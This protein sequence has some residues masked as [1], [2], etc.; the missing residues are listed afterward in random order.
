MK[1]IIC[2]LLMLNMFLLVSAGV[3]SVDVDDDKITINVYGEGSIADTN[4]S[5]E[6]SGAEVLLGNTTCHSITPFLAAAGSDT[7]ETTRVNALVNTDCTGTDKVIGVY[8]NGTVLCGSDQTG[9]GGNIKAGDGTYTYNDTTIIYF[10]STYAGINLAV[11]DSDNWDSMD[12]IN[13]TQMENNGGVLNF[14]Q[15]WVSS[16]FDNFLSEKSTDDLS[17]GTNKY[18]NE[19]WN[20][21]QASSIYVPYLGATGTVNLSTQS[22]FATAV[23]TNYLANVLGTLSLNLTE[24]NVFKP[25]DDNVVDLGE[26][27]FK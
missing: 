1:R 21:S 5:T 19:S 25:Y 6:C 13:V 16:V 27:E 11:N 7:N 8:T 24:A 20:Q 4:A 12:S 26:S 17:E 2:A 14:L 15:S 23:G 3:P 9:A 22:L 10:N 18:D